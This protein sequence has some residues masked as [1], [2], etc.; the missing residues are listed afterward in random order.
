MGVEPILLK[1]DANKNGQISYFEM[2][3]ILGDDKNK[4]ILN[5][6]EIDMIML[7]KIQEQ[8]EM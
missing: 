4:N 8:V 3:D 5:I 7:W 2:L 6:N 1:F